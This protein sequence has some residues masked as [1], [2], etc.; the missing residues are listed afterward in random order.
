MKFEDYT[1]LKD[2]AARAGLGD[3]PALKQLLHLLQAKE[4]AKQQFKIYLAKMNDWELNCAKT[5]MTCIDEQL[6]QAE[7]QE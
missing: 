1:K 3:H 7:T 5:V 6:D 4:L 2:T